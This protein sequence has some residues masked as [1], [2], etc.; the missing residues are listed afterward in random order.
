M[1]WQKKGKILSAENQFDWMA[2]YTSP[3]TGFFVDDKIYRLYF[4]TR[5]KP[6]VNGNFISQIGVVDLDI[7]NPSN[8]IKLYDTS[9]LNTGNVGTFDENGTMVAEIVEFDD[10]IYMYY[11]GWQRGSNVPYYITVGLAISDDNGLSFKKYS[12]GPIIGI[13]KDVPYG[14]GNI[15]IHIDNDKNWHMWYTSYTGWEEEN[16][17][18]NPTYVIKYATS[19][20]GLDWEY[21]DITCIDINHV[22]ENLATPSVLKIDNKYHMWYSVRDSFSQDGGSKGGYRIGYAQSLD[23]INWIRRDDEVGI[24]QSEKGWDSTMICY[25]HVVSHQDKF[26]MFYCGNNYG[27]DGFGYAIIEKNELL[28]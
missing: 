17:I 3:L 28:S 13:S 16:S 9:L 18:Y 5:K 26:I 12:E 11:M 7:N 10:K 27:R 20:N 25:P 22:Q 2:T 19:M 21:P 23:K 15:S 6:D 1:N 4:S 24:N 14:V 8:I